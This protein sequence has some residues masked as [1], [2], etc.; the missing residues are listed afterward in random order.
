MA[1]SIITADDARQFLNY[2]PETGHLTWKVSFRANVAG[3]QAGCLHKRTGYWRVGLLGDKHLAHRLAWLIV[4]GEWPNDHIDH[5]NG[6]RS[7]NRLSNLRVASQLINAQNRRTSIAGA[8]S[9]LLGAQWH[10]SSGLWKSVIR[11]QARQVHI[12]MFK[13]EQEAHQAYV[14]AKRVLHEGNTL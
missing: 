4:H 7:D 14:Q 2:N 6:N 11:Y 13:T 10:K 9:S 3:E 12:G 1:A 5:I 8:K